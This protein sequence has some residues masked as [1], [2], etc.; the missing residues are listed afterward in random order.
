MT[1]KTMNENITLVLANGYKLNLSYREMLLLLK[2][3]YTLLCILSSFAAIF[4]FNPY[5]ELSSLPKLYFLLVL[6]SIVGI[7]LAIYMTFILANIKF[8][9]LYNAA[10]R[11]VYS[12]L[13]MG[14][15]SSITAGIAWSLTETLTGEAMT[16]TKM[17]LFACFNI[18]VAEFILTTYVNFLGDRILREIRDERDFTDEVKEEIDVRNDVRENNLNFVN[19]GTAKVRADEVIY[20]KSDDA[21]IDVNLKNGKN[22]YVRGRIV[23]V[24]E[25]LGKLGFSPHRSFW[26]SYSAI[27]E[28]AAD[29]RG[30]KKIILKNRDLEI[31]VAK[32]K[33]ALVDR[34][35]SQI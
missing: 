31:P 33:E 2:H 13:S 28:V 20:V 8:L 3:R 19:L 30:Y 18:V 16:Y 21:Y 4:S 15:A 34:L 14:L 17:V 35:I 27:K 12:T 22:I 6:M 7:T 5:E 26:V 24:I 29:S 32:A 10:S 1:R 25:R 23:D 11:S 9:V